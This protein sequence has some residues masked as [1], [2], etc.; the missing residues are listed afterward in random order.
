MIDIHT[1]I[2][3]NVDDGSQDLET[4]LLM[5]EKEISDGVKTIYLTP[6]VQSKVTK[7]SKEEHKKVFELLKEE[8]KKRGLDV[9]LVLGAEVF[10]R[11]HIK[12]N[13]DEYLLG[14]HQSILIEFSFTI[15][16][17]IESIV[18]DLKHMGYLPIVAH[19]E[20]YTYLEDYDYQAI[21]NAGGL[22]QVNTTSVLGLDPK[23]K[24]GLVNHLL[25]A[26]LIDFIASDTHNMGL[27]LPNLKET[28]QYLK[29]HIDQDYL[30]DLFINNPKKYIHN[31]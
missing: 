9:E 7:A 25:K 14:N 26:R 18:Y 21:K 17:D 10:Y 8:V 30:D 23:V 5:I 19:V 22:L 1:H 6:H 12:T 27:R 31:N 3:P 28:Y 11:D 13:F 29:K 20:R 4:S 15:P 24:K 2:L 16:T